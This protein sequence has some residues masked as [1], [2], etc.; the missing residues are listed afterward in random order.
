M[1]KKI[2]YMNPVYIYFLLFLLVF[3]SYLMDDKTYMVLYS[4]QKGITFKYL[5]LH[6]ISFICFCIGYCYS[7]KYKLINLGIYKFDRVYINNSKLFRAYIIIYSMCILAYI[8]WYCNFFFIHGIGI[9]KNFVSIDSVSSLMYVMR[10]NSGKISGITTFTEICVPVVA[11]GT[12]LLHILPNSIFRK[13]LYCSIFV[14]FILSI[15]RA[16]A[17]SERLAVI[18]IIVP[19]IVVR[20]MMSENKSY[21]H[22]W[23]YQLFPILAI[24]FL[25]VIFGVF[26]YS[27][28][29]QWYYVNYYDSYIEFIIQRLLGYY[30]SAINTE[31]LYIEYAPTT[32]VPYRS[33]QWLWVFPGMDEVYYFITSCNI[34]QEFDNILNSYGN[35]E[36]NNPGGLLTFYNDF[37]ILF[38]FF[39][40]CLGYIAGR[41]YKLALTG[42]IWG[43]LSYSYFYMVLLELPRF[44]LLGL[45]K[46]PYVLIGFFI[47]YCQIIRK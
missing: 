46:T 24:V 23:L 42:N 32:Y 9:L 35:P 45:S 17:F 36:Y 43:I 1:N 18:E 22:K 30:T 16:L 14:I 21:K 15:F 37:G 3:Y 26:E 8:I 10:N 13:K 39:Q 34:Q 38:C 40:I 25:C 5:I 44:F 12:Y 47:I 28:S 33:F 19:I 11:L 2:W 29:W 6:F 27:R 20:F 31:C 4:M 7:K 41:I